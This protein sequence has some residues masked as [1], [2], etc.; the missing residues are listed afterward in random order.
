MAKKN[1]GDVTK[2]LAQLK[3]AGYQTMH[4]DA[5]DKLLCAADNTIVYYSDGDIEVHTVIPR[6]S[7]FSHVNPKCT[8]SAWC[9]PHGELDPVVAYRHLMLDAY[10]VQF[11][12]TLTRVKA[13]IKVKH[14]G[15][16]T[17]SAVKPGLEILFV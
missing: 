7:D 15:S 10:M 4:M 2:V 14:D 16:S 5:G 13:L 11:I 17:G 12:A 3:S 8:A 1:L 6:H 9:L